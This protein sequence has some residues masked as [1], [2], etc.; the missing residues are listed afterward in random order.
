MLEYLGDKSKR[1]Q[2][3]ENIDNNGLETEL[4]DDTI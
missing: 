4:I 2:I 1:E 3:I